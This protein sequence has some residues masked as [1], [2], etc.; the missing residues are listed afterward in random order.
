MQS[1]GTLPSVEALMAED[2]L[3]SG[4]ADDA[5]ADPSWQN[6]VNEL[7][8]NFSSIIIEPSSSSA[9]SASVGF[10]PMTINWL[11]NALNTGGSGSL[12]ASTE[13]E[14][15]L[16]SPHAFNPSPGESVK[17]EF[18]GEAIDW[19]TFNETYEDTAGTSTN[20]VGQWKDIPQFRPVVVDTPE[21]TLQKLITSTV[22]SIWPLNNLQGSAAVPTSAPPPPTH[23]YAKDSS[24]RKAIISPEFVQYES[25][26]APVVT[27]RPSKKAVEPKKDIV[28]D[29]PVLGP[30]SEP[31]EA[32]C[33]CTGK[34]R[35]ARCA[36]V[37]AGQLCGIECKCTNC[38]NPFAPM[39]ALGIDPLK[40]LPDKC[41][42]QNLSR[43][44][45]MQ[46]VLMSKVEL[47]CSC[48]AAP[49][50]MAVYETL[51]D[52]QVQPDKSY[53]FPVKCPHC[54]NTFQYSWCTGKLWWNKQ[55]RK[56]CEICKRC[57]SHR[58]QHCYDCGH[59][60]FAGVANSFACP[61]KTPSSSNS[62]ATTSQGATSTAATTEAPASSP[63]FH[64]V[65]KDEEKEQCPVQ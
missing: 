32:R 43:I 47:E 12:S 38:L 34:C 56:H 21:P 14:M 4:V 65:S 22:F 16:I 18:R 39:H 27:R 61:C 58:N 15:A 45:D 33:K 50:A 59:C 52:P 48:G 51:L 60:Y 57:G 20:D 31:H 2:E 29:S 19:K 49:T 53:Q 24:K 17:E 37:K 11:Q 55:P 9:Q 26:P 35:N 41:L 10:S 23:E 36:C 7:D 46:E 3:P 63:L 62:N 54:P 28:R 40:M 42:M 6:T 44:K 13:Q 1:P 5:V 30:L 8:T 64:E 25:T